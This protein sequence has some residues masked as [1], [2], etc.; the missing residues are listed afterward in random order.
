MGFTVGT[1]I[2]AQLVSTFTVDLFSRL[3]DRKLFCTIVPQH[4]SI[5]Y[6]L[7]KFMNFSKSF[8]RR[9][10]RVLLKLSS[11]PLILPIRHLSLQCLPS[12]QCTQPLLMENLTARQCLQKEK[13]DLLFSSAVLLGRLMRTSVFFLKRCHCM[14]RMR[15]RETKVTLQTKREDCRKC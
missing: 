3:E 12:H 14:K 6:R 13:I 8:N 10:P 1:F 4:I 11:R 7:R 9:S 15:E 5:D 2:T